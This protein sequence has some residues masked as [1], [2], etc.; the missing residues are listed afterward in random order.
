MTVIIS[1]DP[2]VFSMRLGHIPRPMITMANKYFKKMPSTFSLI[3]GEWL[4]YY[5]S[6]AILNTGHYLSYSLHI[7]LAVVR[8]IPAGKEMIT[9]IFLFIGM[10][11]HYKSQVT[12]CVASKVREFSLTLNIFF[13]N[14]LFMTKTSMIANTI[15]T[16][17]SQMTLIYG[18][19]RGYFY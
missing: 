3:K 9:K 11:F 4:V 2:R 14:K 6:R 12:P 8:N 13:V 7:Y 15:K 19:K 17:I 1:Y 5:A 10:L 18:Y 16:H